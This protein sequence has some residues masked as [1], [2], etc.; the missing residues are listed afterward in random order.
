VFDEEHEGASTAITTAQSWL[1][2]EWNNVTYVSPRK[3]STL[4]TAG[5]YQTMTYMTVYT[6]V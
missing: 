4:S 3:Q 5:K 2:Y 6:L 1:T